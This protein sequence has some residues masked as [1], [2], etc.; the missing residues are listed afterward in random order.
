MG[1]R[2]LRK[3]SGIAV[4]TARAGSRY[5][6]LDIVELPLAIHI[7]EGGE[8]IFSGAGDLHGGRLLD[9]LC[10]CNRCCLLPPGDRRC[11]G[12]GGGLALRGHLVQ[13]QVY[14]PV[15]FSLLQKD[16]RQA[17]QRC[18]FYVLVLDSVP[19]GTIPAAGRS[20]PL[21]SPGRHSS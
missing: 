21:H 12:G 16:L 6:K 18:F 17:E 1:F 7:I 11:A 2:L 13:D 5:S 19:F 20:L 15:L 10:S 3:R 9:R 8:P 4:S 14:S